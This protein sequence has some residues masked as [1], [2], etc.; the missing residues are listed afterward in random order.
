MKLPRFTRTTSFKLS[1]LYMGVFLLSFLMVGV[2]V[3]FLASRI[4]EEQMKDGIDLEVASLVAEYNEG[5]V[6]ALEDEIVGKSKTR[7]GQLYL[8]GILTPDGQSLAGNITHFDKVEGWIS[9][10]ILQKKDSK[11]DDDF[12]N[13][14]VVPLSKGYWLGVGYHADYVEDALDAVVNAFSWGILLVV[15][16]GGA[17][18]FF[19][20]RSFLKKIEAITKS[21]QAIIAGDLKHRLSVS[22]NH[23]EL[24]NLALLLNRMLDKIC[25]LIENI[26][27][28]SNDI[29]HDLRTPIGHLKFRLE[30]ALSKDLTVPQYKD[31]IGGMI[32]EV[33][34]IL[35]TFS[36][37]LRIAQIES[38][39]RRAG[40]SEVNLSEII[41]SVTEALTPV[42]EEKNQNLI[43]DIEDYIF[44]SGDKELLTQLAYNLVENS[45]VHTPENTQISV[46][47]GKTPE[48]IEFA[49]S[50]NGPGVPSEQAEKIF[51]RF[52]RAER[53]RTTPGNG[54]GLSIV[55][56][57]ADL[58]NAEIKLFH[59]HSGL[60]M[61]ILFPQ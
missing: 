42:A 23:D 35:N 20:T 45:I 29:A 28:V 13:V 3:Y 57:I 49:V 54:L 12:L 11:D 15:M 44:L 25:R 34:T 55:S 18:G 60:I 22:K 21:T 32:E 39:S 40:F 10:P 46:T 5:G 6:S 59:N 61:N 19:L 24:D 27:Q 2:M 17:G 26:Q 31:C 53:S 30:E 51:Q 14:K 37:L 4:L 58:H 47:L 50:D 16:A 8:Y 41:S 48:G 33:D 38:G 56:A 36:A 43:Y 1:A 52:Y 7:A 9:V